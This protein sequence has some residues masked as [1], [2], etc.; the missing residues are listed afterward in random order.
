[1]TTATEEV[2]KVDVAKYYA[3][4][5]IM[6]AIIVSCILIA[7]LFVFKWPIIRIFCSDTSLQIVIASAFPIVY[8]C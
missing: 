3:K 4:V 6:L 1:M 2:L 5:S 7:I 8:F